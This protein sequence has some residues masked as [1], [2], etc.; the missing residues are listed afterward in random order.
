VPTVVFVG[1]NIPKIDL[2]KLP[3]G[4]GERVTNPA[5]EFA[6]FFLDKKLRPE[7]TTVNS[8]FGIID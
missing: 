7:R 4:P 6:R 8:L 1:E 2:I 3:R 5:T